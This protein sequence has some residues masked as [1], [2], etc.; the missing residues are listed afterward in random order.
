GL[1]EEAGVEMPRAEEQPVAARR[2]GFRALLHEAA[3]RRDAGAGA[4]HDDVAA[5]IKRNAE[6]FVRLDM[7]RHAAA[8]LQRGEEAAG[9]AE[10]VETVRVVAQY[11]DGQV[12]FLA[13]ALAA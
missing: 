6:A 2:T 13:H 5:G 9:R 3:E 11:I 7:D 4:D 12:R 8:F 10:V 1:V